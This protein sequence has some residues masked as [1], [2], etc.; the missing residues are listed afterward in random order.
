M[1]REVI[2]RMAVDVLGGGG[3][4][5]A[6]KWFMTLNVALGGARPAHLLARGEDA[7]VAELLQRLEHGIY[8]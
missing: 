5:K 2:E 8:S 6:R 4:E 7:K 3:E 1:N